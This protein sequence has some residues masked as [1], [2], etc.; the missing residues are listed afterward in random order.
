MQ[1]NSGNGPTK[2]PKHNKKSFKQ[3]V[4]EYINVLQGLSEGIDVINGVVIEN[5]DN[6][7]KQSLFEMAMYFDNMLKQKQKI[8]EKYP[9]NG[10][11]WTDQEDE[12]LIEEYES[13]KTLKEISFLHGRGEKAVYT[14]LFQL[15]KSVLKEGK[16]HL[17]N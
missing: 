1:W 13:G 9:R 14:R 16:E 5:L 10:K 12:A 2:I 15:G 6:E 7:L 11:P 4:S 17:F 8:K 3:K